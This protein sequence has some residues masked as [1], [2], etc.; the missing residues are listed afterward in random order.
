MKKTIYSIFKNYKKGM[1]AVLATSMVLT[2]VQVPALASNT[3]EAETESSAKVSGGIVTRKSVTLDLSSDDLRDAALTAIHDD[4]LFEAQDYLGATSDSTKAIKEYEA[5]FNENPGLY[6]VDVPDSVRET[7]EEEA[8]AELRIFVQK[9]ARTAQAEDTATPSELTR[10]TDT[11]SKDV[12]FR[13]GTEKDII[14][15]EP[16]TDV[17]TLIN[18][19]EDAYYKEPVQDAADNYDYEL[20]GKEKITFM[21]VN[22]SD[23]ALKFTLKVDDVT[24]DQ[25]TVS[26]RKAALK[27]VIAEAGKKKV[28]ETTAAE[29]TKAQET[30][31]TA[32]VVTEETT[33][34]VEE[35][36]VVDAEVSEDETTAVETENGV[37]SIINETA[38]EEEITETTEEVV[39]TAAATEEDTTEV[40]TETEAETEETV[41]TAAETEED[42]VKATIP[43]KIAEAVHH[44]VETVEEVVLGRITALA[45][46][47][48][49]VYEMATPSEIEETE[50]DETEEV[51]TSSEKIATSSEIQTEYDDFAKE[52]IEEAKE[53]VLEDKEAAMENLK[54]AKIAQ[55]TLDEL[56]KIHYEAEIDGYK[57]DVFAPQGAFDEKNPKLQVKKLYK[58]EEEK[59]GDTL[60]KDEIEELKANDIYDNSQALDIRFVDGFE[61]EIEPKESVKVRITLSDEELLNSID[62][63]SLEVHHLKEVDSTLKT[64]KVAAT[65]D[66]KALDEND[67][68]IS[69][70]EL[71]AS[72]EAVAEGEEK[73]LKVASAVAEFE[74]ESFSVFAIIWKENYDN[75]IYANIRVHYI[76]STTGKEILKDDNSG[77][78]YN[79][80]GIVKNLKNGTIILKDV[81]GGH[82]NYTYNADLK[83]KD[84]KN[85]GLV[86][87]RLGSQDGQAITSIKV[88][89]V[90]GQKYIDYYNG[91]EQVARNTISTTTTQ[92]LYPVDGG[93][94]D[95][96]GEHL[97]YYNNGDMWTHPG[98]YS[99]SYNYSGTVYQYTT[100]SG[101]EPYTG[102]RYEYGYIVENAPQDIYFMYTPNK[103]Q[104]GGDV[105]V[106]DLG[107]PTTNKTVENNGDGTYTLTLSVEGKSRAE[108]E[109]KGANVIVVLD[110]SGSMNY[111]S[112]VTGTEYNPDNRGNYYPDENTNT[113]EQLQHMYTE[114]VWVAGHNETVPGHKET[115][116]EK[117]WI[118]PGWWNGIYY[119]YWHREWVEEEVWVE[120]H[121][122]WVD[123]HYED[124]ETYLVPLESTDTETTVYDKDGN[125]YTGQRFSKEESNKTRL[126]MAKSAVNSLATSLLKNNNVEL[127]LIT[128]S[129]NVTTYK[130]TS[131]LDSFKKTVNGL[132]ATGGTNWE[133][134]LLEANGYS[135]GYD[136]DDPVYVI[137]V[138]DGDP[139]FRVNKNS[140]D[141]PGPGTY[142]DGLIRVEEKDWKNKYNV[143]IN[144]E[145]EEYGDDY[146][147]LDDTR[148]T[149]V[150]GDGWSDAWGWNQEAAI[151]ASTS[152]IGAN[153]HFYAINAFRSEEETTADEIMKSLF[154]GKA[155]DNENYF[156][157]T[158]QTAL[159]NAFATIVKVIKHD[160]R[161]ADVAIVDGISDYTATVKDVIGVADKYEYEITK[162]VKQKVIGE[163]GVEKEEIVEQTV[164]DD[165]YIR[166]DEN[167]SKIVTAKYDNNSV[168]WQLGSSTSEDTDNAFIL[169]SGYTYKVSFIVWPEQEA[170]DIVADIENGKYENKPIP[171]GFV[172]VKDKNGNSKY[173][174]QTNSG[175]SVTYKNAD[176]VNGKLVIDQTVKDGGNIQVYP[177]MELTDTKLSFQKKW[178]MNTA[179]QKKYIEGKTITLNLLREG[180]EDPYVE[181]L[182]LT[183]PASVTPT[184][185]QG[186]K[187]E[188][189]VEAAQDQQKHLAPG[190]LVEESIGE[191]YGFVDKNKEGNASNPNAKP[192]V[193]EKGTENYYFMVEEGHNYQFE[194]TTGVAGFTLEENVYHPMVVDGHLQ[195]VKFSNNKTEFEITTGAANA[196]LETLTAVNVIDLKKL[197]VTKK[198]EGTM[199]VCQP[200]T[201]DL[202]LY[203]DGV[204]ANYDANYI[205]GLNYDSTNNTGLRMEKQNDGAYRFTIT[206]SALGS[207]QPVEIMLPGDVSYIIK[208]V[209]TSTSYA[210]YVT[211]S[212]W[213]GK[214]TTISEE[215]GSEVVTEFTGSAGYV[216]ESLKLSEVN[217]VDFVN[218]KNAITPTGFGDNAIPFVALAFAGIGAMAFL[219]YDFRKRSLFED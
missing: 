92:G 36:T 160:L 48:E 159:N 179:D 163:D 108:T 165:A 37:S 55:Y 199:A 147:W 67:E 71:K 110:L 125:L 202:Y 137:F 82:T 127:G 43:E 204:L 118:E 116:R 135:F 184:E 83:D 90:N 21:F 18:G 194:E 80:D 190:I 35:T 41:E 130:P 26:G 84:G 173:V 154:N 40:E 157:A 45:D 94:Y 89:T 195:D 217:K 149:Y 74:V 218:T 203:K 105:Q 174:Y 121:D 15:Y 158:S 114:S 13:Y 46:E 29:T 156:S 112:G 182:S 102:R 164:Y 19:G 66:V 39:E 62:A 183:C 28:E 99:V 177:Y 88:K 211:T 51:E 78:A 186:G 212:S 24:Y 100:D 85:L 109:K 65:E 14:L 120:A 132:S 175:A 57:V 192:L 148:E 97:Y 180:D 122:V 8:D 64:E 131:D 136:D 213:T 124:G 56:G 128:F 155:V 86:G 168:T 106:G 138:S 113:Y 144:G 142:K 103:V 30:E 31:T 115:K 198:Y 166:A 185:V 219:A 214:R 172:E 49:T 59:S 208:E 161:Y 139:T 58:P 187:K 38:Q 129:T 47:T 7:L 75:N 162:K 27:K 25:V 107:A 181:G 61:N 1:A 215:D 96:E 50:A 207:E 153:K 32:A 42:G 111:T 76:D 68:K 197:T 72:A 209:K 60:S 216:T 143:K 33:V 4:Q 169:E 98:Y 145:W 79:I 205:E 178:I 176:Y 52:R 171:K 152:L 16:S 188:V 206:P 104:P 191:A 9:D 196:E 134:A 151:K 77:S 146:R 69:D 133:G 150:Y 12:E 189:I 20:T 2:G 101:Y 210:D 3:E 200:T 95:S 23:D 201:F 11:S 141:V 63:S 73:E 167:L 10:D 140:H 119:R 93:R 34:S 87:A 44:A 123:G 6:V 53:A 81:Q 91:N 5:F 170:Y 193:K 126:E 54:V 17:D 22:G 117:K 70:E